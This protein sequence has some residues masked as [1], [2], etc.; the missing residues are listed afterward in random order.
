L[1]MLTT[2]VR[3]STDV[4]GP[5][6]SLPPGIARPAPA[7]ATR[8]AEDAAVPHDLTVW[9]APQYRTSRVLWILEE[10]GLTYTHKA[11]DIRAGRP[12][13][14]AELTAL[15]PRAKIP[16]LQDGSL[17][18]GESAAILIY[19]ADHYG[20]GTLIPSPR[21]PA[22]AT[23]DMWMFYCALASSVVGALLI[24]LRVAVTR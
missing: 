1:R 9:G 8:T 14:I 24:R 15:N 18:L 21:T 12:E 3:P 13:D 7:A 16:A 23:H 10:L 20:N 4:P 2:S 17:V 19:L 5:G 11:V 6:V 22:R